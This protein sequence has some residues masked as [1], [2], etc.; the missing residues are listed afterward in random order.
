MVQVIRTSPRT[1]RFAPQLQLPMLM[2]DQLYSVEPEGHSAFSQYG[3]WLVKSGISLPPMQSD[4]IL[5]V[6]IRR[7]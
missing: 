4:D 6:R 1:F 7:A 5:W 3:D 2:A